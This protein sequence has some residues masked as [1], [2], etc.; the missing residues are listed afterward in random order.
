MD[1]PQRGIMKYRK[2]PVV[3]EAVQW[4]GEAED[5]YDI[6]EMGDI[7]WEPGDMG[8]ETFIIRTLEGDQLVRKFDYVIKGTNGEFYPCK[9]Y[10]FETIYEAVNV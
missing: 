4:K 10:I 6:M 2:K 8:T 1:E 7:P 3:I 5:W 9:P